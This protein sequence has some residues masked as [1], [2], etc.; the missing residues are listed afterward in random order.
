MDELRSFDKAG[1]LFDFG[2][3]LLNRIAIEAIQ[4]VSREACF[5]ALENED[6]ENLKPSNSSALFIIMIMFQEQNMNMLVLVSKFDASGDE[7]STSNGR[8]QRHFRGLQGLAYCMDY[9]EKNIDWLESKLKPLLKGTKEHN[10]RL[11]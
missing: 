10:L 1:G 3:P 6:G 8:K 7:T 4:A 5:T 11:V 9:L 2:H